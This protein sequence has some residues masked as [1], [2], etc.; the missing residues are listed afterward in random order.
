MKIRNDI[1]TV[2]VLHELRQNHT[3]LAKQQEKLATGLKIVGAGDDASTYAISERMRANIR[4][5]DQAVANVKTGKSMLTIASSAI[6]EQV[7]IMR[8]IMARTMQASDDTY[9]DTDRMTLN[10]EI[11][12][13]LDQPED[14]ATQTTY[15][16]VHLLDQ[17]RIASAT[18][19]FD[20]NVPYHENASSIVALSI[21]SSG[22]YTPTLTKG[23]VNITTDAAGNPTNLYD[24]TTL[25]AGAQ[26]SYVPSSNTE[27]WDST[28]NQVT[29]VMTSVG[30]QVEL[31]NGSTVDVSAL[32]KP[33]YTKQY[34]TM[35]AVGTTAVASAGGA[36]KPLNI[37]TVVKE[38]GSDLYKV[39][40]PAASSLWDTGISAAE[41]DFSTLFATADND[42]SKMNGIGF[43]ITCWECDQFVSFQF[44]TSSANSRL[45]VSETSSKN[46]K[47][48][49][50]LIGIAG[51]TNQQELE[52]AFYNGIAAA[53]VSSTSYSGQATAA[54]L[55]RTKN[56]SI[57]IAKTHTIKLNYFA[58]THKFSI[59]KPVRP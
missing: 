37:G 39:A 52:D 21:L 12:Q 28:T 54:S 57:S 31:S 40:R 16:G 7:G 33:V 56:S 18:K 50:Y 11:S 59:K 43:S 8:Q 44:D 2:Q 22:D 32:Y 48:M 38:P 23:Y 15:N 46:Q 13:L 19:Y 29:T 27:V 3:V 35:P 55:D 5:L 14:I 45:Y 10:K 26:Y 20:A 36:Y 9:S 1:S 49:C 25:G 53:G 47:P 24:P 51:V 42:V 4:G 17:R 6:D 41:I 30:N 58:N 34:T